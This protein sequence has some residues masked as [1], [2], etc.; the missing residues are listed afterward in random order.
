MLYLTEC[1]QVRMKVDDIWAVK[2]RN[3]QNKNAQKVFE[4]VYNF[5]MPWH[6]FWI[7]VGLSPTRSRAQLP[8]KWL[9]VLHLLPVPQCD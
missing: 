5:T 2:T 4:N 6:P 8:L 9:P 7:E 3:H 1:C